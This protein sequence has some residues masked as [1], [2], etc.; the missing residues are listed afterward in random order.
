M[1]SLLRRLALLKLTTS[2]NRK[3]IQ[4]RKH[5]QAAER[6]RN[7][8]RAVCPPAVLFGFVVGVPFTVSGRRAASIAT[9]RSV[10]RAF[11][12]PV[13]PASERCTWMLREPSDQSRGSVANLG[14]N[15]ELSAM[16]GARGRC[17]NDFKGRHFGGEIVLWAVR[18]YCRYAVSYRD[19]ESMMTERGVAVDH[20]ERTLCRRPSTPVL[21]LTAQRSNHADQP[22]RYFSTSVYW[23]FEMPILGSRGRC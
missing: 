19:L 15:G 1:V 21:W 18:W 13:T 22:I 2:S 10:S 4:F 17:V 23:R 3:P 6:S 8:P 16:V 12:P 14:R 20:S 7:V 5:R 9:R 11:R